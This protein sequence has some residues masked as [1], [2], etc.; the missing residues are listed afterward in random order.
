MPDTG[1]SLWAE[2]MTVGMSFPLLG[3]EGSSELIERY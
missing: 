3:C 2:G 1:I